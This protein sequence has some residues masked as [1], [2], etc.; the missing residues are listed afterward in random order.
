MSTLSGG[1][2]LH[3]CHYFLIEKTHY[4]RAL[5]SKKVYEVREAVS[6][7]KMVGKHAG[8]LIYIKHKFPNSHIVH[9]KDKLTKYF[10]QGWQVF[11]RILSGI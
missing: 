5:L 10:P 2:I 11:E 6:L 7:K 1:A 9:I 8:V 4:G 3:F